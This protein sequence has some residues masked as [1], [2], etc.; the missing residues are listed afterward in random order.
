MFIPF[1]WSG[2]LVPGILNYEPRGEETPTNNQMQFP[3][4]PHDIARD[5]NHTKPRFSM[6]LQ[7]NLQQK[8]VSLDTFNTTISG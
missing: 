2:K 5:Y 6:Q 8:Q 3:S 7:T 1:Y 4:K